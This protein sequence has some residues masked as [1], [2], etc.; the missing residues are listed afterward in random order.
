MNAARRSLS[1]E[2]VPFFHREDAFQNKIVSICNGC[3]LPYGVV[4]L[5]SQVTTDTYAS[6]PF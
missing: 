4:Y 6:S 3:D 2:E 5:L 1:S